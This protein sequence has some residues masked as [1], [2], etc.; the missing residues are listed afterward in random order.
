MSRQ[1]ARKPQNTYHHGDLRDAL[2]QAA[3][4]EA[5]QGGPEAISLK[6]L[7]KELGVSQPAPYRHFADREALLQ[8]VTAEAFRQFNAILRE[9]ID[10]PSKRSKLSRFA[11][12]ALDF[13]L[14]RNG[15][16]RLMF[17][18]RTMACAE[19]DSELHVAAH[20]A[21]ALLIE[22]LE[23]PAI[24]LLR[25]RHALQVW[26]ALHGVISLAE[27]GLLTGQVAAITREELVED[28]VQETKMALTLAIEKAGKAGPTNSPSF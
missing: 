13:G 28:I 23:A 5:E 21:L 12:T 24:G 6:A 22:S 17:A 8:A 10:K 15:I 16:Y 14:R 2:V 1:L 9:A 20:A 27:Q 7:A 25:E 3:L 18:S 11:Q 19:K 4:R 26:A